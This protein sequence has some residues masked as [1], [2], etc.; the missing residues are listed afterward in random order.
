MQ[1]VFPF[2]PRLKEHRRPGTER[3]KD[4]EIS[5]TSYKVGP[6][7]FDAINP[8]ADGKSFAHGILLVYGG[9]TA[10]NSRYYTRELGTKLALEGYR[11]FCFDFRSNISG[12]RFTDFGIKD[13]VEDMVAVLEHLASDARYAH[14]PLSVVA[15]SMGAPVALSAL[16][17]VSRKIRNLIL[18]APAAYH[19]LVFHPRALFGSPFF[20][21]VIKSPRNWRRSDIF[22]LAAKL[23]ARQKMLILFG[24]DRTIPPDVIRRYRMAMKPQVVVLPAFDHHP[25]TFHDKRKLEAVL[26][27]IL[28]FFRAQT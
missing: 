22:K 3:E 1:I 20:N 28:D 15:V 24:K 17:R 5:I 13:R 4:R 16:N 19:S 6:I 7:P 14:Y 9:S 25:G 23:K 2:M 12:N 26:T 10:E 18:V 11:S 8:S 27:T 21:A